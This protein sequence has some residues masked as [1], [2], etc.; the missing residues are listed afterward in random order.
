MK[1]GLE[2]GLQPLPA[3]PDPVLQPDV[4][5]VMPSPIQTFEG[6]SNDA[7][8]VPPATEGDVG[9]NHYV[10]WINLQ[11]AVFDKNG[12]KLYGPVPGNT[13][14]TPLPGTTHP[15]ETENAGDPLVHY[16]QFADRWVI[17][18]FSGGS[19]PYYECV[20]VSVTASPLGQY[21]LYP[22]LASPN[23]FNDYP[24]MAVWPD[25]YY[26]TY[27]GFPDSGTPAFTPQV[28][29][30]ERDAMIACQ[31][32]S[33][34]YFDGTTNAA[35][36]AS[37][38]QRILSADVDGPTLPP[39]GEPNPH[40]MHD[41]VQNQVEFYEFHVD[42]TTPV[43]S[44]FTKV[45]DLAVAAFDNGFTCNTPVQ[46]RQCVPQAIVQNR[47]DNLAT[48]L[49]YE[50]NYRNF[51]THQSLV[52]NQTVDVNDDDPNDVADH[53]GIRWYELRNPHGTPT[54]FQQGTFAPDADHR[55]MD[56]AAMDRLGNLAVGYSFS[57]LQEFP[58]MR[59][60]GR[61]FDDPLGQ[62]AQGEATMWQGS[63][64]Q[65][66]AGYIGVG[67]TSRWGDYSRLTVDPVD[68]CTFWYINEYYTSDQLEWI[69]AL[70][71]TRIGSFK[72]ANCTGPTAVKVSSFAARWRGRTIEVGWRTASEAEI[73]GFNVFRRAGVRPFRKLNRTLIEAKGGSAGAATYRIVDRAVRRAERYT[74]RLQ[75]VSPSGKRNWYRIGS[76]AAR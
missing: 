55:F 50:L 65:I 76:A 25:A 4:V 47:I 1:E 12:T 22:F 27:A 67:A 66:A 53:S 2:P 29:A 9:P 43:N 5:D 34:V 6:L 13:V 74:Y 46:T 21:C 70:W 26:F 60:A 33:S 18:Q 56:S 3:V 16:D 64:S 36:G 75:V 11:L 39:L 28:Q 20:A 58:S 63:G 8:V 15:C 17:S 54:V 41:D 45:T 10:E 23:I 44:T 14:F 68:D 30:V 49:M 42:W 71:H 31:P 7:F 51:G 40:V 69:D 32:A 57:G 35:L 61:E 73:L 37:A 72:F 38:G 62:L 48:R 19:A 52:V 59:Y 24:K